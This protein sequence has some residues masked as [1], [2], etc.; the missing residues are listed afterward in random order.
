MSGEDDWLVQAAAQEAGMLHP[1]PDS[2]E[3]SDRFEGDSECSWVSSESITLAKNWRGWSQCSPDDN[4]QSGISTCI[5]PYQSSYSHS[6]HY[7][8]TSNIVASRNGAGDKSARLCARQMSFVELE[9]NYRD[10][11]QR[12]E[13]TSEI[14]VAHSLPDKL[15][16]SIVYWC[17]PATVDDIRLYSCLANGNADEFN[18]GD[19]LYQTGAVRDVVQIG[20]LL[21]AVVFASHQECL[22]TQRHTR[23]VHNV[24]LNVDRCRVVSCDCSCT[25][26]SAWCQHV[27]ALCLYRIHQPNDVQFRVT[28]WDSVNELSTSKLKKF[29]QYLVNELPKEYLPVAQRLLDQL[30]CPES[31]INQSPGAPDPTDGGHEKNAIWAL[32]VEG[33]HMSIRR[34]LIKYCVPAPT[35]HC[36]VQYLGTAQHPIAAEWLT[37]MKSLRAREP[38]GIWNLMA[39]VREMFARRDENAVSL[40]SIL[41]VEC[42]ANCQVLIWWYATK[43]VQNG[44]WSQQTAGKSSVSS[45]IS[46]QL[47]CAQLCDEIVILW[48]CAVLNPMLSPQNEDRFEVYLAFE[49]NL[50][51]KQTLYI[52]S[53]SMS[54]ISL[55]SLLLSMT[56]I[57]VNVVP[58]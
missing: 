26:K 28:I 44:G 54:L 9:R 55:S 50:W 42:L 38:E 11:C 34:L 2:F 6:G 39:I 14:P 47:N 46:A 49:T 18:H 35:V 10:I 57:L 8:S 7:S 53:S 27:V 23:V 13:H 4:L 41:T 56:I 33:L 25:S 24:S 31:E 32:D 48:R 21:S 52:S 19:R 37:I 30:K 12:K 16:L 17:F 45:Q 29:A 20:Y 3:D 43:L 51:L 22:Q 36:D 40:L 58:G 1:A 5:Y 15:F